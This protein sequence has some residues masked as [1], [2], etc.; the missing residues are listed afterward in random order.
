MPDWTSRDGENPMKFNPQR[1]TAPTGNATTDAN[2]G[3]W[4]G[5][6][7]VGGPRGRID[8]SADTFEAAVVSALGSSGDY[9]S[10]HILGSAR[11]TPADGSG[12]FAVG[13][14][15]KIAS[16]ANALEPVLTFPVASATIPAGQLWK[17]GV[18]FSVNGTAIPNTTT[19]KAGFYRVTVSGGA[20]VLAYTLSATSPI[21]ETFSAGLTASTVTSAP[22]S[23]QRAAFVAAGDQ[24]YALGIELSAALPANCV[25]DVNL[26]LQLS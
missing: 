22:T 23:D 1:L 2:A 13:Q 5:F 8:W 6:Y 9:L 11:F 14:S 3:D 7:L 16:A 15:Y 12:L 10:N 19:V 24:V 18:V 25:L 17:V 20:G 4:T 26:S 21:V